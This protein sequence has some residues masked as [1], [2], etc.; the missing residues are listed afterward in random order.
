MK[1]YVMDS[2]AMIAFFEDE[3]GADKIAEILHVLINQKAKAFMSVINWGEIY[4]NIMRVQGIEEAE[5]VIT[6]FNKYP[7][8]LIEADQALTYE[9]AKLKGKYK[10]AYADCFAAALSLRLKAPVVT[11]DPEFKKLEHK[12]S[13]QWIST[14]YDLTNPAIKSTQKP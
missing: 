13:I 11:G 3:P 8:Q 5:D 4:Y 9:A 12:I 10:I 1:K 7:I 2:F 14:N 6:Q